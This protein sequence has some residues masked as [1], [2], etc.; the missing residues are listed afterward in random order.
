M[1]QRG[2]TTTTPPATARRRATVAAYLAAAWAFLFGA[3]SVYWALAATLGSDDYL[4]A[5]TIGPVI[6]D[7]ATAGEPA[8]LALLWLTG[9]LKVVAGLLALAVVQRWG[10]AIPHRLL[11][12]AIWTAGVL[13]TLYGGA[14]LIQ[15][16][17]MATGIIDTPAG[18]G[19]TAVRWHLALWDPIWLVG[20]VLF[21]ATAWLSRGVAEFS[22][23]ARG[24]RR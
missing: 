15:H 9:V 4:G 8:F 24:P 16:A 18:L 23:A 11:R 19:E 22:P 12:V 13:L 3:L 1:S 20:G 21:V 14:N 7:R 6:E 5:G 10:R 2:M 17:L